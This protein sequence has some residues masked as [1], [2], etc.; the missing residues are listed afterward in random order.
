MENE[1]KLVEGSTETKYNQRGET[2]R[3]RYNK[4]L[5]PVMVTKTNCLMMKTVCLTLVEQEKRDLQAQ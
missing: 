2:L 4:S 1:D 5:S 3:V